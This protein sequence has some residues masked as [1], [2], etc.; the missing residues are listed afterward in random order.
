[1]N[2]TVWIIKSILATERHEGKKERSKNNMIKVLIGLQ[3]A[4]LEVLK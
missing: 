3:I 2:D 4:G 1:M